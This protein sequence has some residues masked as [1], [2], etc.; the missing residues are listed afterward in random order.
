M[1]S[2]TLS[3]EQAEFQTTSR[4]SVH[5]TISNGCQAIVLGAR[6]TEHNK[7]RK[8]PNAPASKLA[9]ATAAP[10]YGLQKNYG[11]FVAG[12]PVSGKR[13]AAA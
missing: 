12:M 9:T 7:G 13:H 11:K 4:K 2:S 1:S 6:I 8:A 3:G 10:A 5:N